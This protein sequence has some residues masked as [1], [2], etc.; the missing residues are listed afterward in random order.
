M[1]HF[2]CISKN[3][4]ISDA[5]GL[6]ADESGIQLDPDNP[7]PRQAYVTL[8]TTLDYVIGAQVLAKCLRHTGTQRQ[9]VAMVGELIT[10]EAIYELEYSGFITTPVPSIP[11]EVHYKL[12]SA[13]M[14]FSCA[15][16][17]SLN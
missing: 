14:N 15:L 11:A 9:F 6:L 3:S 17:P 16:V 13:E 5:G 1:S 12:N 2:F 7:F 10:E 8:V 4:D